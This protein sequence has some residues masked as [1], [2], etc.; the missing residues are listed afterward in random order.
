MII[1]VWLALRDDAQALIKTRLAWDEETQGVYT[2][3]VTNRQHKLFALMADQDNVQKM[4]R[5]DT[6]GGRDWTLW[7]ISFSEPRNIL[8]KVKDELDQLIVDFPNHI[9][10]IG[11][12]YWDGREVGTSFEAAPDPFDPPVL[13][14]TPTYPIHAR[15]LELMPDVDDVGTRPTVPSDVNLTMGQS[16]RTFS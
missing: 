6:D 4:F 3:P 5:I 14:G 15:I 10:I 8:I 9:K 1:N 11:A 2:G 16:P 13:I 7:S 12:W